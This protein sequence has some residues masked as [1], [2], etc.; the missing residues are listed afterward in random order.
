VRLGRLDCDF[1]PGERLLVRW[2]TSVATRDAFSG[3]DRAPTLLTGESVY[4]IDEMGQLSSHTLQNLRFGGRRLL[5]PNP[6]RSPNASAGPNLGPH[7]HPHPHPHPSPNR[8]SGGRQLLS[9]TIGAW[10]T[11]VQRQGANPSPAAMLGLLSE[12]WGVGAA[13]EASEPRDETSAPLAFTAA[14]APP[15]P[16]RAVD[17]PPA[18]DLA[19]P[20]YAELHELAATLLAQWTY[21]LES[22]QELGIYSDGLQLRASSGELLISGKPQY[23]NPNPQPQPQPQP[24]PNP[25]PN[26]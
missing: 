18:G 7:A 15:A 11:L 23:F 4:E 24:H 9:S 19:W 26:H 3:Q 25:N 12:S 6:N 13:G 20:R 17:P 16:P 8:L 21:L 5:R 14:P 2:N 1:V 10:V 22:P